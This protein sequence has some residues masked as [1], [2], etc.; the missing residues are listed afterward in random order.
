MIGAFATR[1]DLVIMSNIEKGRDIA[2]EEMLPTAT[3]SYCV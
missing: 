3:H 1:K 2:L